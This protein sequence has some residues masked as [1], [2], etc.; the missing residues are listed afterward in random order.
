MTFTHENHFVPQVYLK[1]FAGEAGEVR[2][3]RTLVSHPNVK[4]WKSVNAA[5][6]GYER[7]LYTRIVRGQE[8][9]DI[10]QWLSREF[11]SPAQTALQKVVE[12][13]Q[14]LNQDWEALVR[15]LASQIVRTPAFLVRSLPIWNRM[16]PTVLDQTM[17]DV[18][19]QLKEA[20]ALGKKVV[21]DPAPHNEYFPL[22]V[23][24]EPVPEEGKVKIIANV[25]IGRSLWFYAM[26]HTLTKTLMV[27]HKHNWSILEAPSGL[28]W[29]TSDD[30]VVL[31]NFRSELDFDFNGGWN[32][33]RG[34]I[35]FPLSPN[36]LMITEIGGPA[37]PRRVP[38]R[39][40]ARLFRRMIAL[41]AHRR[42]Y[43]LREDK[44]V[45][46]LRPRIVDAT[47]FRQERTLWTTWYADQSRAE[48][49]L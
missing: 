40:H 22:R 5:G 29:F 33:E 26:K 23:T 47:A 36:H 4:E 31:L 39:Y 17:R 24:Q 25:V 13:K 43:S 21:I 10:E 45:P 15:F 46:I 6:T 30:P 3:Y 34:N 7:D 38:S 48:E 14:L 19:A 28:E 44:K 9:D 49:M 8:A 18:E 20:Q 2:E 27:L 32:R 11:E 41:H 16:T 1:N 35:I 37:F 12:E 42:I